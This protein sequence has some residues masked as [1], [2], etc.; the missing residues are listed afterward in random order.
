ML[1]APAPQARSKRHLLRQQLRLL[2]KKLLLLHLN[3]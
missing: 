2:R 1:L 3:G